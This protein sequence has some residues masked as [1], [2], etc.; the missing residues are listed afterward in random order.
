LQKQLED[1]NTQS[2]ER[3]DFIRRELIAAS[4]ES[5]AKDNLYSS[6]LQDHAKL[7]DRF[8]EQQ[9]ELNELRNNMYPAYPLPRLCQ[10]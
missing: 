9:E 3:E 7:N 2:K 5:T 1:I 10:R 8:K 4:K 6:L